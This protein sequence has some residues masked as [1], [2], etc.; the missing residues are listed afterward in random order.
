MNEPT[1]FVF[2]RFRVDKEGRGGERERGAKRKRKKAS[3]PEEASLG[4]E[5]KAFGKNDGS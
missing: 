4:S 3:V 2:A 5:K 1:C